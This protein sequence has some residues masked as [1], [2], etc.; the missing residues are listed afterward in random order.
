MFECRFEAFGNAAISGAV[1]REGARGNGE[2]SILNLRR[3]RQ[4]ES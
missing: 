3:K 2:E 4:K 1:T